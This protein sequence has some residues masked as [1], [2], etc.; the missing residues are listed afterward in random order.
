MKSEAP[1]SKSHDAVETTFKSPV[2]QIFVATPNVD[3][4]K[5]KEDKT[6]AGV[7]TQHERTASQGAPVGGLTYQ[8]YF[9]MPERPPFQ[10]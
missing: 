3:M 8:A 4:L 9:N 1:R 2:E 10:L 7:A 5:P 6:P